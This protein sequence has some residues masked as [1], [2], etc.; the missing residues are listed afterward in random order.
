MKKLGIRE[1]SQLALGWL[2]QP[3]VLVFILI[4]ISI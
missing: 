2:I 4:F 1:K 3:K